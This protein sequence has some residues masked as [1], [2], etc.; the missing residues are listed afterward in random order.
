MAEKLIVAINGSPN[1][2]DLTLTSY[3]DLNKKN[4]VLTHCSG[5]ELIRCAPVW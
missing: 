1:L 5:N 2:C 3:W 4:Y